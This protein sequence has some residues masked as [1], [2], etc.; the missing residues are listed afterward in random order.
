MRYRTESLPTAHGYDRG[1]KMVLIGLEGSDKGHRLGHGLVVE[2]GDSFVAVVA[3]H[4]ESL[5]ARLCAAVLG[6]AVQVG[7]GMGKLLS[8]ER[9]NLGSGDG[10]SA[11]DRYEVLGDAVGDAN[12]EARSLGRVVIGVVRVTAVDTAFSTVSC[13]SG[14]APAGSFVRA[15]RTGSSEK[16]P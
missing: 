7:R 9:I 6:D 2:V 3:E 1:R 14:Q 12:A 8:P 16:T 5:P 13:E 15:V 11:D 4:M 10:V